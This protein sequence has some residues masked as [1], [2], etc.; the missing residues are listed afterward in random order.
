MLCGCDGFLKVHR[1][2][3]NQIICKLTNVL[4]P[5]FP[6]VWFKAHFFFLDCKFFLL[7]FTLQ[8]EENCYLEGIQF[9]MRVKKMNFAIHIKVTDVN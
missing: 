6:S 8:R 3:T 7:D 5:D 4:E 9:K 1:Y 2:L